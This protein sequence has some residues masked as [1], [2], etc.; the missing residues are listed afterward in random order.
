M[1]KVKQLNQDIRDELEADSLRLGERGMYFTSAIINIEILMKPEYKFN[2]TELLILNGILKKL[3]SMRAT[4][5]QTEDLIDDK[6]SGRN[7]L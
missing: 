2:K 6:L 1:G 4:D 5:R 7:E 3:K